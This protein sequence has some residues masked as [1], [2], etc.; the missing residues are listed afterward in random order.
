MSKLIQFDKGNPKLPR[1]M[2]PSLADDEFETPDQLFRKLCEEYEIKPTL[3]V[4][5][6]T[7][8]RRCRNF[9]TKQDSALEQD[10]TE[11]FWCNHPHTMHAEFVE[12]CF[13]EVQ[14][15]NIKGL[16]IIPAN[17]CRTKYWHQYIEGK[18]KY[19]AIKGAIRFLKNGR[20]SKDTSRNA[21]L[22]VVWRKR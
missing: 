6:T 13:L 4:A 3:D 8:N 15:N 21:Y 2:K 12:K 22:V 9:F 5:A 19:Y 16:M 14:K 7:E 10:W 11:D 20:P 1:H 17:C 18:M